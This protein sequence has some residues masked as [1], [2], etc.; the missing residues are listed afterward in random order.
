MNPPK[1]ILWDI[2]GTLAQPSLERGFVSFLLD[3]K[4]LTSAQLL[5]RAVRAALHWPPR[6]YRVKQAYVRN[7]TIE[8]VQELVEQWWNRRGEAQLLP[9]ASSAIS[10]L[11]NRGV[12]SVLLTGTAD[13]LAA[14]VAR[15]FGV[16]HVIAARA[17][18]KDGRYTGELIEPHPR[19]PYKR[20]YAE[21]FLAT[22]PELWEHTWAL[23]D[24]EDDLP[25]LER[26][27][28]AI[29]VNPRPPLLTVAQRRGWPVVTDAELPGA[30]LALL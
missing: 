28:T 25:L 12:E 5:G 16:T 3:E 8:R 9:G 13:F 4:I 7:E 23:A 30:L 29:A 22:R 20:V 2:D 11:L 19:G 10:T 14:R 24:H 6:V 27:G 15:H 26:A 21:R 17:L 1:L 18:I